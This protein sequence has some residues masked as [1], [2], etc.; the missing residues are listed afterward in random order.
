MFQIK[1]QEAL[2]VLKILTAS[3]AMYI[4]RY[5]NAKQ[6]LPSNENIYLNQECL[7]RNIPNYAK[8]KISLTFLSTKFTEL[9]AQK[10]S[11]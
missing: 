10:L 3:Q 8:L 7:K 1:V 11:Y 6:V 4:S 2:I 5:T 9:K